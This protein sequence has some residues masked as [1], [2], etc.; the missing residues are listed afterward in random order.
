M[1]FVK[2]H[3][4]G[5][6]FIIVEAGSWKEADHL[7]A[8]SPILCDRHFGIGADGLVVIGPDQAMDLFM[9]I[10]NPDGSEP[11]MCGNAIRCVARYAYENGWVKQKNISV[12][13]LAGI[14]YPQIETANGKVINVCVDMGQ[15]VLE[16]K[17]IPMQ[18]EGSAVKTKLT[19][20]TNEFE[21]TAVSMGNP[22][23]IHFVDQ[24]EQVPIAAWGSMMESHPLF[25]AKTN[26]EFVQMVARD[27]MIMRVWERGAGITMACGTGACASLV[28]AVL[29]DVSD[30][31][32]T[33]H[34]LGGDLYIEWKEENNHVYMTGPA[35]YVFAGK[36]ALQ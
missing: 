36:I 3:G 5:N 34:L 31:K 1:E 29:N 16:R 4:L 10:F 26:V 15:P 18:G 32:A 28:A 25:P 20:A 22:H 30:R 14:R 35:E 19:S 21:I 9:R 11:E 8:H 17:L 24:I 27:E 7:Q 23:C 13:T 33:I 2:M 6:D 12:R